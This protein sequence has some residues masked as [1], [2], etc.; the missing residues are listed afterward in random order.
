MVGNVAGGSPQ[1]AVFLL[2][3]DIIQCLDLGMSWVTPPAPSW[4]R[5][6]FPINVKTSESLV[7]GSIQESLVDR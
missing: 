3:H 2:V 6:G 1:I 4:Y 7:I 5:W